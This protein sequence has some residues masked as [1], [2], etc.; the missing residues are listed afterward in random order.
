MKL[1]K[2]IVG[3]GNKF[4]Q[5]RQPP[6]AME[7]DADDLFIM[8]E[9]DITSRISDKKMKLTR[10]PYRVH[11]VSEYVQKFIQLGAT[12]QQIEGIIDA[13]FYN[14][15]LEYCRLLIPYLWNPI[16][17]FRHIFEY[18]PSPNR[19]VMAKAFIDN[20]V[21]VNAI[22]DFE[23]GHTLLINATEAINREEQDY[24]FLELLIDE[25]ANINSKLNDI[26][27]GE[28]SLHIAAKS[29]YYKVVEFLIARGADLNIRDTHGNTPVMLA[30][31][32]RR[33]RTMSALIDRGAN[34]NLTNDD[35]YTVKNDTF[36]KNYLANKI[37]I[38]NT[39]VNNLS[40]ALSSKLDKEA[41]TILAV[42][43]EDPT[44][45]SDYAVR[46]RERRSMT[47]EDLKRKTKKGGKR[48]Y[49]KQKSYRKRK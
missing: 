23:T 38:T 19:L 30:C 22:V 5:H 42:N 10:Q 39:N 24:R 34:I 11:T 1:L 36:Y 49:H 2:E 3:A 46:D 21:D 43:L 14:D 18:D 9:Q 16:S 4:S 48:K 33:I 17:V 15:E 47:K 12:Q 20:D 7:P 25:G 26:F 37:K 31:K 8:I 44:G 28:S 6:V 40:L 32:S 41:S 35:R 29:G 45:I 27:W 13:C